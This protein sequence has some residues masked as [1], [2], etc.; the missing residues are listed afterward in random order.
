MEITNDLVKHL[1]ELSRIELKENEIEKFKNDFQSIVNYFDEINNIDTS[2]IVIERRKLNAKTDLR[3]D[4]IVEGLK[5][6]SVILNS[7]ES[8][9]G[10]IVVPEVVEE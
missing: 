3:E 4:E 2:D 7:P 6:E 10:A 1:A 5:L 9:G 8:C